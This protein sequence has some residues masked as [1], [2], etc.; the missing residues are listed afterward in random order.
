M[1]RAIAESAEAEMANG[2]CF[3][4]STSLDRIADLFPIFHS[5]AQNEHLFEA[6][7]G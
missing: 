3:Q 1:L 6:G 5:A 4:G 2:T 7:L